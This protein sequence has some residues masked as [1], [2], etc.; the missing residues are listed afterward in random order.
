[1]RSTGLSHAPIS[2]NIITTISLFRK[3]HFFLPFACQ[4]GYNTCVDYSYFSGV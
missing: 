4:T 3:R 2:R 1:V